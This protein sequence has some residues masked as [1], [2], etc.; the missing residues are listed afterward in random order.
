VKHACRKWPSPGKTRCR[1][2][3]GADQELSP[4]GKARISEASRREWAQWRAAM[5]LPE[6]WRFVHSRRR[7]GRQSAAQWLA[8]HRPEL[9]E[10]E[11]EE[12]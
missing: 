2:H 10:G 7:G 5:G 6:D 3:G 9:F 8:K 12:R 1:L 4:D 11:E